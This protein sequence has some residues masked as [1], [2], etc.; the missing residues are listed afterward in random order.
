MPI[1]LLILSVLF[2]CYLA[3]DIITTRVF[4]NFYVVEANKDTTVV[5]NKI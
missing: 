3:T 4:S 5:G 1:K 2:P